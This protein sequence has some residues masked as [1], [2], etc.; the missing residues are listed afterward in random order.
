M[1]IAKSEA[2]PCL[3]EF[4]FYDLQKVQAKLWIMAQYGSQD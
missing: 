3:H 1:N 2:G 4:Y